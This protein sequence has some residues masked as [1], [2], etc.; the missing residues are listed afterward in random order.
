MMGLNQSVDDLTG[1]IFDVPSQT[2]AIKGM[3]SAIIDHGTLGIEHVIVLQL[4]FSD[5]EVVLLHLGLSTLN[6]LV[7][8]GMC[9]NGTLLQIEAIHYLGYAI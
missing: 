5:G 1:L 3:V 6:G 2:L 8:P 7:H 9:N 4:P